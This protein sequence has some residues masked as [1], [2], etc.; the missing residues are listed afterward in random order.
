VA[1]ASNRI[2]LGDGRRPN[3]TISGFEFA[4]NRF[5]CTPLRAVVGLMFD[6]RRKRPS[7]FGYLPNSLYALARLLPSIGAPEANRRRSRRATSVSLIAYP[8]NL[9][10]QVTRFVGFA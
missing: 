6:P 1:I 5:F 8:A 2:N 10:I 4:L 7:S 3:L 9:A